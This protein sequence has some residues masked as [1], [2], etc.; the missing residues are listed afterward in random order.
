MG[1]A[2]S[3]VGALRRRFSTSPTLARIAA[4]GAVASIAVGCTL[5]FD[6]F[7]P[8]F[9]GEIVD[10]APSSDVAFAADASIDDGNDRVSGAHR[11]GSGDASRTAA[12]DR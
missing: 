7:R 12:A 6:R 4:L 10:A 3:V 9:A 5:D 1:E 2:R 11:D 8:P